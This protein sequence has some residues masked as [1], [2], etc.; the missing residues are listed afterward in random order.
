M[1]RN[2]KE[3]RKQSFTWWTTPFWRTYR[4]EKTLR[5][6]YY[7]GE[8]ELTM[9]R[10]MDALNEKLN[11]ICPISILKIKI[12]ISLIQIN[13]TMLSQ[14]LKEEDG[15][16][17]Q[18]ESSVPKTCDLPYPAWHLFNM[19]GYWKSMLELEVVTQKQIDMQ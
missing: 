1:C 16:I 5:R 14:W 17:M 6:L 12:P 18:E 15:N 8:A 19:E 10:F 13:W 11:L 7:T 3:L 9:L 4:E 2:K